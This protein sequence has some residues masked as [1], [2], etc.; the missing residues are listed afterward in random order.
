M[1]KMYYLSFKFKTMCRTKKLEISY[2]KIGQ[3]FIK[4]LM[5]IINSVIYIWKEKHGALI[6]IN[7]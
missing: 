7:I 3:E 2:I 6:V 5:I 1:L 4:T